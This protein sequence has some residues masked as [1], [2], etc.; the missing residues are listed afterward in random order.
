MPR[1]TSF[2]AS[3]PPEATIAAV[4]DSTSAQASS[5]PDPDLPATTTQRNHV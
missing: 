3:T 2:S 4:E 5:S 1:Q